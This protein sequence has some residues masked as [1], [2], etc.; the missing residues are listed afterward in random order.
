MQLPLIFIVYL[1]SF[2]QLVRKNSSREYTTIAWNSLDKNC[3]PF[4]LPIV[5]NGLISAHMSSAQYYDRTEFTWQ[6][7]HIICYNTINIYAWYVNGLISFC[8]NPSPDIFYT[9]SDY[10]FANIKDYSIILPCTQWIII[11][12]PVSG[13][14]IIIDRFVIGVD[15]FVDSSSASVHLWIRHLSS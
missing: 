5:I 2:A 7:C 10:N 8:Q 3:R 13:K 11:N 6:N 1:N 9:E 4:I 12:I 15:P 14:L